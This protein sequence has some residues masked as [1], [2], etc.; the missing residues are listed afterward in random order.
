MA[1]ARPR[2]T[3]QDLVT[4]V[5]NGTVTARATANDGSGVVGSL[6]I[7]ISGQVI[8]VTG[9]TVTGASGA[10]T[11]TTD[12][13]TL[14]LT[15]TVTPSDATNKTVTWSVVNGTGQATINSTGLVT[16]VSNGTVT[17]RA[18]A[19][20]GSGVVG[21]LVITISGQVIPVTGITVTGT[22][23]ATTITTDNGTLQLTATVTPSDATT[24]TVTWS[25]VN[26]TGQATINSTGLV[27]AVANGTVT[28]RAT[29]NDGSGV[30]GSLVITISGQVIPVTGITVTG[31]SGSTT[32]TTDN[33]TLQ[34]TATVTPSDATNKTVTWSV[35][36]GTGQAT[37]NSTGLVT[38]VTDGTVTARA[39]ANDGS[40][41][42]G[43]LII[44]I[45]GQVIPV[46]GITVTGAGGSSVIGTDNGQ[47]QLTATITP[48]NATNQTVTWSIIN[49]TGQAT[50]NS[51]G[52]VT[53]V[54]SGTVTAVATANDGSGV[55]GTL[56]ITITNQ[57]IPVTNIT[58]TGTGGATTI[59][60]DNGTL[61]LTATVSPSD[62]T[63]KTVTWS[64][65]NG[66]GQ[67]TINST[68]LV[69]A[70][71]NGTVTARA[72]AND[73]SGVVGS[74]IIT[75]SG[76]VIPVTGITV[77][78]TGGATTITTD[79]GTLQLTATVTPSDATNKTVTWSVVNGTGQAS[80]NSTGLLTAVSNGTVTARAT[81]NDGSGVVGSLV[82]TISGQVIP[83][84][85]I[86]VTGTGGATTITT[87]NGTLQLTA[88]VTPSDATNKTVTWSVVNGT[89]QATI[90]STG[91]V[92]A[93]ANGTVTARATA[94]DGSGIVGS[95]VITISGQVIPVT[96]IT[97]TGASG[98]TTIT[99]D[100]GTL[101]LTA[102]VTPSDATNKTVTWS[103]VNGTG[104]ATINST[105]LVTA[106]SN[107]TVTARATA[108]DGSGVVGS[109]II[110]ISGQIIPVTGIT[111]TGAG[112][113]SVI[114]TDNGQL[115]L[116]ATIAP[117]NATNQTV[118]WSIINGTGQATIN[119]TGLVTA[120]ASGTVTAVATAN[121]G[122]GVT[123]TLV[124]TITNQFIPVTSI[125]ITGA[126][127]STTI[128]AD[129]GTLQLTATVTPSDATNKTVTWSVVNGTGQATIN[130]TGLVTAVAD[131]TVTAR[132]TANDGSG[133]VGSLVITISGQEIP[134][135][136]IDVTSTKG[137]AVI[138]T[139][140]GTLQLTASIQPANATNQTVTWSVI[141]NSGQATISSSGLVTAI[142][143][144]TVTARATAADGSGV[145]GQLSITISNQF[146]AVA[147]ITVSG[148][149]GIVI[150]DSDDGTLQMVATV[151]PENATNKAVTWSF[152]KGAGH[153]TITET[154]LVTARS[155]G[156]ITVRATST[157]G[158]AV[159]GER[160]ISVINQIVKVTSIKV[161]PKS[162]STSVVTVDGELELTVEIEPADAT[163]QNV[164]W[165]VING[166]GMAT[167]S[168][169]GLLVG[170]APGDVTVVATAH[171]GSGVEGDLTVSIDLVESIKIKYNRYELVVQVPERLIP[172]KAS[173][174]NLNGS[175]IQTKVID[176]T[177]CIFDIAGLM[178]GIYVVSVYNSVV[179][180]AAKIV[181]AY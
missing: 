107:G 178:P 79:N 149:D 98:A 85:G 9:I 48:A 94:N 169:K 110:T 23:G 67:A 158:S 4:A 148:V 90:N 164:T 22:G 161:K 78:G 143:N 150:I 62:A 57:F 63:N 89:G 82:I 72:T 84:T 68:G 36:N 93:V 123:G 100:N 70:V 101:Q 27:T 144:G 125:A 45:S 170:L 76:Q 52:L 51:T 74:L 133:V 58:V 146:V 15:A 157:D 112:G 33:G 29:A 59:T 73:G 30:V 118:T 120:V 117:S 24:K 106:V 64:V 138:N 71:A 61:Q 92:T 65:V 154:G 42:V 53:A 156:N 159:F 47:L 142:S 135:T 34:L 127:G 81:A 130:S 56:V 18:T 132:A 151:S 153:A 180:D 37:I 91:L 141:N 99:T 139:Q 96:G 108:N 177:E 166:T 122:S 152:V 131:G 28:A 60:T 12:N 97:V 46:T 26:G 119:S 115:Q 21:S 80:I 140:N 176:T 75:I 31:A 86:T 41:V 147:G 163:D 25:V 136:R 165:S 40:G 181:I 168:E 43:S 109:L 179:Q 35:V 95:L 121:D 114:G 88:T 145:Y 1:R 103:V 7:T 172:A 104:Q 134:V 137:E 83:V 155:N 160:E 16:A 10:T 66:T 87:D 50:I 19:N 162:K 13:G 32:I 174:H 111:V 54:T 102:T 128:T 171:D 113:S 175:H 2:S 11:I 126:S 5:S 69:T 8:P 173:L 167:I 77:T 129:N 6:V 124:I 39:T 14:Q 105:G 44:T 38:A 20:D 49:G 17:A 55:T 3:A 116:T